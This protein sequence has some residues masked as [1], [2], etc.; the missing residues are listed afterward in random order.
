MPCCRKHQEQYRTTKKAVLQATCSVVDIISLTLNREK[1]NVTVNE[2]KSMH[3][4]V[5]TSA[6]RS[7]KIE[8]QSMD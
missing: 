1:A 5:S 2:G 3:M 8:K 7:R 6:Q 4:V